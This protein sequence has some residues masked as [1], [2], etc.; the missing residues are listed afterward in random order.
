MLNNDLVGC[1]P[2]PAYYFSSDDMAEDVLDNMLIANAYK[3]FTWREI[4][5][6]TENSPSYNMP[7]N[8]SLTIDMDAEKSRSAFFAQ[9]VA[10]MVQYP[11]IAYMQQE[12][13][14]MEKMMKSNNSPVSGKESGFK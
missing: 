12:K 10:A 2:D 13:N 5:G 8:N 3:H 9:Q 1:P 11:G 14:N 4:M 6:V 7:D